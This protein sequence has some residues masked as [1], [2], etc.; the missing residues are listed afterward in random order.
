M[1]PTI[2]YTA[3][4][5][6]KYPGSKHYCAS[7][8]AD[9][10][11]KQW[12]DATFFGSLFAGAMHVEIELAKRGHDLIATDLNH[13]I[14]QFWRLI[15]DHPEE[16]WVE[17]SGLARYP[18]DRDRFN[19]WRARLNA[20]RALTAPVHAAALIL[21]NRAAHA[22]GWRVNGSGEINI[23]W[24]SRPTLSLPSEEL[25]HTSSVALANITLAC[26]SWV[27]ALPLFPLSTPIFADPPYLPDTER[28]IKG[29]FVGYCEDTNWGVE[30]HR[31][32]ATA[33]GDRPALVC[34]SDTSTTLTTYAGWTAHRRTTRPGSV[35]ANLKNRRGVSEVYLVRR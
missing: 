15:R 8:L 16:V 18:M 29:G 21:L 17:L 23:P 25:I 9:L 11:E 26:G 27:D 28:H 14:I 35:N 19:Q 31:A 30:T 33:L 5:L 1:P 34:G 7:Y 4:V 22:P 12:P 2:T 10:M 32:L 20:L 3:Q 24:G 6:L 13:W